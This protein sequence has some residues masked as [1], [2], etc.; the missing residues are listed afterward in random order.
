MERIEQQQSYTY[1]YKNVGLSWQ[2]TS[3]I[4]RTVDNDP[5]KGKNVRIHVGL[6]KFS[7][8]SAKTRKQSS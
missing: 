4:E 8:V 1:T 5:V 2:W 3:P 6:R 7:W